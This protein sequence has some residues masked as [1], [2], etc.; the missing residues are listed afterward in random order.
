[1]LSLTIRCENSNLNVIRDPRQGRVIENKN[2][3]PVLCSFNSSTDKNELEVVLSFLKIYV[4]VTTFLNI[5]YYPKILR[6]MR[7]ISKFFL[8]IGVER[9][10]KVFECYRKAVL[11][12]KITQ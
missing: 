11:T 2:I 1:M 7:K 12:L 3:E 6:L 4:F 10:L 5:I 9:V 8:V